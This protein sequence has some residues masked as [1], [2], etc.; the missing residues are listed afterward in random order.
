MYIYIHINTFTARPI[1]PWVP[2]RVAPSFAEV[3]AG[4]LLWCRC[5]VELHVLNDAY[6]RQWQL[7]LDWVVFYVPANTV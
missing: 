6:T 4:C 2:P 3:P 7:G 1:F 5:T